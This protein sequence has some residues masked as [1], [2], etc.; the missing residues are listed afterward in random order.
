MPDPH[1]LPDLAALEQ[2]RRRLWQR[3]AVAFVGA[4]V[5]LHALPDASDAPPFPLW[6][7]LA[8][9]MAAE[10]YPHDP[11][12]APRDALRLAQEYEQSMTRN[13][14]DTLLARLIPN[15]LHRPGPLHVSLLELPW[16]DVLTTNYDTL[17]ERA[18]R[19]SGRRY[20]PVYHPAD[21]ARASAPRIV[22]LHGSFPSYTPFVV[23]E[24]DF[25][26]YP[27][28]HAPFVSLAQTLLA[29]HAVLLVGF[30]GDDPNFLRWSGW[31]RDHLPASAPPLF[32]AGALG[33]A[34]PK[35]VLLESR[36]VSPIDLAPLF[37][38]RDWTDPGV[39]HGAALRWLLA[40]LADAQPHDPLDWP[41]PYTR[42]AAPDGPALLPPLPPT[43]HPRARRDF[44][45]P[46]TPGKPSTLADQ[47]GGAGR[48]WSPVVAAWRAEREREP[49]W[50]VAP[51]EVRDRVW[52]TLWQWGRD[53]QRALG[54]L[55]RPDDL[56]LV[57]EHAWRSQRALTPYLAAETDA[58]LRVLA[59]YNPAPHRVTLPEIAPEPDD[60]AD[61]QEVQDDQQPPDDQ[62]A[63]SDEQAP[64]APATPTSHPDWPWA[65]LTV[66]WV[67]L[68]LIALRALRE[69][70]DDR[71]DAWR[72]ALAPLAADRP[73]WTARLGY[74]TA[75]HA[76]DRLD[77]PAVQDALDAWPSTLDGYAVGE[78]HRAAVVAE[79]GDWKAAAIL[80]EAV[81]ERTLDAQATQPD[82]IAL[83]SQE[84][85]TRMLLA[86]LRRTKWGDRPEVREQPDG[87]RR[88]LAPLGADPYAVITPLLS[89]VQARPPEPKGATVTP[90][91]DP[92]RV[93]QSFSTDGE[94]AFR[95]HR[96]AFAYIRA[97]EDGGVPLRI[98]PASFDPAAVLGAANWVRPFAGH[99]GYAA[100]LRAVSADTQ[101][102]FSRPRVAGYDQETTAVLREWLRRGL[103]SARRALD[104]GGAVAE[105]AVWQVHGL[106]LALSRLLIRL[107]DDAR[108]EVIGLVLD[109]AR[110]RQIQAVWNVHEDLGTVLERAA[111]GLD[112]ARLRQRLSDLMAL[113]LRGRDLPEMSN[114]GFEPVESL[115]SIDLEPGDVRDD[116]VSALVVT[117]QGAAALPHPQADPNK[118]RPTAKVYAAARLH[119]LYAHGALT[120]VQ[121]DAFAAALWDGVADDALPDLGWISPDYFLGAPPPPSGLSR[122]DRVRR[123]LLDTPFPD[124]SNGTV[125]MQGAGSLA[126]QP[127]R[128]ATIPESGTP[129]D[130]SDR[131]D[132]TPDEAADILHRIVQ[133]WDVDKERYLEE[134]DSTGPSG[135]FP[136]TTILGDQFKQIPLALRDIVLPRIDDDD[137]FALAQRVLDEMHDAGLATA[138]AY[139]DLLRR[140]LHPATAAARI[141]R[142][143]TSIDPWDVEH[144]AW[145]VHRWLVLHDRAGIHAPPDDLLAELVTVAAARRRPGLAT[146]LEA[147]AQS[148]QDVPDA[149][150]AEPVARLTTALEYLRYETAPPTPREAWLTPTIPESDDAH[151]RGERAAA[152][153]LAAALA[154]WHTHAPAAEPDEI[155]TWRHLSAQD[156]LPEVRRAWN[157]AEPNEGQGYED[158]P[159]DGVEDSP[160]PPDPAP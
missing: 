132:W 111:D 151:R 121:A 56:R 101:S 90:G 3:R 59:R 137:L 5:S 35:R 146:V 20:T 113:P 145:A 24:E 60:D 6:S 156:P 104:Q 36:G 77:R 81:L 37:P 12:K 140:G 128:Q 63:T 21:L 106:L 103:R 130:R 9:A 47:V 109:L 19:R 131:I 159:A 158:P 97:R 144:G 120:D 72:A 40:A 93:T 22:K 141:R 138:I 98:G 152:A 26:R 127:M 32:L 99:L 44:R 52:N 123:Q 126:L 85:W 4:G 154:D 87:W 30:S 43:P 83:R 75:L 15:D 51:G 65:D 67:G 46:I 62:E 55:D 1:P 74:Q 95:D 160:D 8:D 68:G 110:H 2:V 119:Y 92:G 114:R 142:D 23:T 143:L 13:T 58:A 53:V 148:L 28:T 80:A 18:S 66:L 39:R 133:W 16:A 17:L 116:V 86:D 149:F 79:L 78:L 84:G 10:L 57:Y 129:P 96:P 117:L 45:S 100:P 88:T 155:D 14:L 118:E 150:T 122:A 107:G 134:R 38:E 54:A 50:V 102:L 69:L 34:A 147:V 139:P 41:G 89:A 42:A 105:S 112:P 125:G 108:D 157:T 71:Y 70:G 76:L 33:L 48:D 91:F 61:G 135:L 49:G 29:E 27:D 153:A 7:G 25:R 73:E 94:Y 136:V 115:P 82:S 31:V 11:S 124:T 64:E